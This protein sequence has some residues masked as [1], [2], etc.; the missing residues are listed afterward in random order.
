ML[1]AASA[2]TSLAACSSPAPGTRPG[3]PHYTV[4]PGIPPRAPQPMLPTA[5]AW[6][7]TTEQTEA[8]I[9]TLSVTVL[10]TDVTVP[11]QLAAG[12]YVVQ[13]STPDPHDNGT[14]QVARPGDGLTREK[15]LR[16]QKEAQPPSEDDVAAFRAAY[17]RWRTSATFLGGGTAQPTRVKGNVRNPTPGGVG[18]FAV[19]LE[20]GRYW[21]YA[22]Y[23]GMAY[24]AAGSIREVTV[25]GP[26]EDATSSLPVVA[27]VQF[28]PTP[29]D[30]PVQMPAVIP[31]RGFLRAT[32]APGYVGTLGLASLAADVTDAELADR[33]TCSVGDNPSRLPVRNCFTSV[34][35][36]EFLGGVSAGHAAYWYYDLPPGDYAAS[37]LTGDGWMESPNFWGVYARVRVQ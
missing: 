16:L 30:V 12:T 27:D 20:P 21:F 26:V 23:G 33:R 2:A 36:I 31:Q 37:Q 11:T 6:A 8:G 1:A 14:V 25:S 19:T 10:G 34:G 18:T 32:G 17:R 15:F 4:G 13:V 29:L 9:K 24:G 3:G 28:S 22:G 35:N 5:P 7:P